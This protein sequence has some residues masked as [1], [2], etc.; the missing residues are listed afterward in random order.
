[1]VKGGIRIKRM[2]VIKMYIGD[3]IWMKSSMNRNYYGKSI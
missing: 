2:R 1:V 3:I